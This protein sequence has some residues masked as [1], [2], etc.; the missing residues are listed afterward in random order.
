MQQKCNISTFFPIPFL[1]KT[2]VS[3]S[4]VL[5]CI[6]SSKCK[7]LT[8]KCVFYLRVK[9]ERYINLNQLQTS[10]WHRRLIQ[11]LRVGKFADS[12]SGQRY[13]CI[14][15]LTKRG[16]GWCVAV[17]SCVQHSCMFLLKSTDLLRVATFMSFFYAY[18]EPS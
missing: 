18:H 13:S 11:W 16:G 8:A 10:G 2:S 15:S 5:L 17:P 4:V 14:A 6:L 7:N 1:A 9:C 12:G 3:A